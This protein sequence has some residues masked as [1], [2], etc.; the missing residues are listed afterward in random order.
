MR[1]GKSRVHNYTPVVSADSSLNAEQ[2]GQSFEALRPDPSRYFRSTDM[3]SQFCVI[4]VSSRFRLR[5]D[6]LIILLAIFTSFAVPFRLA[7]M[8]ESFNS[9]ENIAITSI[10]DCMFVADLL[11][12]FRTSFFHSKTG[13]EVTNPRD[14]R[15]FYL[16]S[17]RF[18]SDLATTV[19]WDKLVYLITLGGGFSFVKTSSIMII[20]I[21]RTFEINRIITNIQVRDDFKVLLRMTQLIVYIFIYVHIIACY[22]YS[23]INIESS[24]IPPSDG[25]V[26]DIYYSGTPIH[27]KYM[28]CLYHSVYFLRGVEVNPSTQY[29]VIFLIFVILIGSIISALMFGQMSV[30]MGM[31]ARRSLRFAQIM[32]TASTTM[33]NIKLNESLQFKIYDYLIATQNDLAQQEEMNSF[34][35]IISPSLQQEVNAHIYRHIARDCA[36]VGKI[37]GLDRDLIKNLTNKF[38]QPE[39]NLTVQ[40]EEGSEMYFVASGTCVVT[41]LDELKVPHIVKYLKPGEYFGEIA[42]VYETTRTASVSSLNYCNIAVLSA[43]HYKILVQS[44][45]SMATFLKKRTLSYAD[46]WKVFIFVRPKQSCIESIPYFIDSS[47]ELRHALIYSFK[48]K[49]I[50]QSEMLFDEGQVADNIYILVEGKLRIFATIVCKRFRWLMEKSYMNSFN[51]EAEESN[52]KSVKAHSKKMTMIK[53]ERAGLTEAQVAMKMESLGVGSV[54]CASQALVG[55]KF[56]VS[57][58]SAEPCTLLYLTT[59]KLDKLMKTKPKLKTRIDLVKEKLMYRDLESGEA[60]FEVPIIDVYKNFADKAK[61]RLWLNMLKFKNRVL[62]IAFRKRTLHMLKISDIRGLV[63]KLKAINQ[64]NDAGYPD[65]ARKIALGEADVEAVKTIGILDSR[66]MA[67]PLLTQFAAKVASVR[68]VSASV[69][70]KLQTVQSYLKLKHQY[71]ESL[72]DNLFYMGNILKQLERS[73]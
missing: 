32:D 70:E 58:R 26:T 35:Q 23:L 47:D 9:S 24:W 71:L 15:H 19:P 65:L 43:K 31:L 13:D 44:Y 22:W 28:F 69:E 11:L 40:G 63:I 59:D 27:K 20:R 48:V 51:L 36:L 45:Q 68:E 50:G 67:N 25:K 56:A 54:L 17:Y 53:K 10:I 2:S 30:L 4:G 21:V 57:C 29:E 34:E 1:L 14:I 18:Y 62:A 16:R 66:E 38:V 46:H 49:I 52:P 33:K 42:L 64:A 7:F 5:W 39:T 73:L 61:R 8:P 55:S 41:V 72:D 6:M 37:T 3:T 12:N 60:V